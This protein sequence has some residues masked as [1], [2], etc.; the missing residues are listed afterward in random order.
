M[1]MIGRLLVVLGTAALIAAED[2]I[3]YNRDVRPILSDNCFHCHGPDAKKRKAGL[4]LHDRALA[5]ATLRDSDGAA[6]VPGD[7][8]ASVMIA[9]IRSDD[10]DERMPPAKSHK[11]L[12]ADQIATLERWI[13][14]GAVYEPH[15]SYIAPTP[16]APPAIAGAWARDD[17]D[18]FVRARLDRDGVAPQPE[19][20]RVALIRRLS[21]DLTGLPPSAAAV[22]AFL[23][24]P[25]PDAYERLVDRLLASPRYGERMA[26][27]W[28]DLVRYADSIGYHSDN[29]RN[30]QPYR[31]YVI[32]A[33]N[34][35]LPFERFTIEQIAGDLLPDADMRTRVASGYNRL[36]QTTEEGGAQPK[37]Y[38]A[39]NLA[40][41][42]RNVST[43]WLGAT[44]GCAECHDHKFDPYSAHDFAAL[45]A[46]FADVQEA[47]IGRREDGMPVP[48]PQ[49]QA[50]LDRLDAVIAA[51]D[52]EIAAAAS[53][54]F[55]AERVAW[56]ARTLGSGTP[57]LSPW[58]AIGPFAAATPPEAFA[59]AFAP[60]IG[61]QD[62]PAADAP[63]WTP[64]P[65]FADGVVHPLTGENSAW[66]LQRT[67]AVAGEQDVQLSL[68]SDDGFALWIDGK[69][70]LA[71][72]VYRGAA[73]DQDA[74]TLHLTPG[75]H[76]ILLKIHNG[77]G[78]FGFYFRVV[79]P[80][81]EA[82]LVALRA[83]AR[84]AAQVGAI[85][86][87]FRS[88]ADTL[89][90][91]RARRAAAQ[92]ERD[93]LLAVVPTTLVSTT[94]PRR[95]VRVLPRGNWLDESGAPVAP[96]VPS[97]LPAIGA[98]EPTRLDLARWLVAEENP[99]TARVAV[100]RLWRMFF[101][102]GL[103]KTLD[104]LGSQG[105][106]PAHPELLDHLATTFIAEGWSVKKLVRHLVVS[107]TYRQSSRAPRALVERDPYNRLHARQSRW[108]LD[109]EF[110]R[111]HAL[112]IS[113]L[114]SERIG[115][116]SDKPYQP[117]GYW[118]HLNF[119]PREWETD[120]GEKLWRRGLY[121]WW[122]RTFPHPSLLAF[123]A[124]SREECVAERTRSNTPLA[125]LAALN[126]P[127]FVEAARVFAQR[128]LREGGAD[129]AARLDWAF[130][131][132]VSRPARDDERAVLG[133]LLAKHRSAYEQDRAAAARLID[134]GEAPV[135]SD[136]D[137]AE[138]AAWTSVARAI[139]NL[140]E[141]ITRF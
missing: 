59:T 53:D 101:G 114:L 47:A 42:V 25:A 123:D 126:D 98:A 109:A 10:A 24:D 87:Y 58:E 131:Q 29:P 106:Y 89:A 74:A 54:E 48:S 38:E 31:D 43:A 134:I 129:A 112:A 19:A 68:G 60:E 49:Q 113:G 6:I 70:V 44:I 23:A 108:R 75:E 14:A 103:S 117:A 11:Q 56:E 115:G 65:D 119:P 84:D 86:V 67:I 78:G 2:G 102:V 13:A 3:G 104:D 83:T 95:V 9:R 62:V 12:S 36:L 27:W 107:A 79:G 61:S 140:H 4:A 91:P 32:A 141:T 96:G 7:V 37:E 52:R 92:A 39:K 5:L 46:F 57:V 69:P 90:A 76:R 138:L 125:A 121:T 45:G 55:D 8:E 99:L 122:Q 80:A 18:R 1:L 118:Q 139:L 28:L 110:V 120:A 100:N 82:V 40:D 33:F 81:P 21:A 116:E 73:P 34:D 88:I 50:E 26:V 35:D 127:T 135:A 16:P 85:D 64:R 97:F 136:L 94:G 128:I 133:D 111:D 124:P 20:D 15:W 41:R 17:L 66:Y 137:A 105:E 93:A 77:G 71:K 63:Q 72:E 132:A 22:E 30:V 51:A 130:R